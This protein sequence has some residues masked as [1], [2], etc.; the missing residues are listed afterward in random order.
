MFGDLEYIHQTHV[1]TALE[2]A[3]PVT[4]HAYW[5]MVPNRG[6]EWTFAPL[7]RWPNVGDAAA[8]AEEWL[9]ESFSVRLQST[10]QA[11][12]MGRIIHLF[13]I[14]PSE[15]VVGMT[16]YFPRVD[17][18]SSPAQYLR[19]DVELKRPQRCLHGFGAQFPRVG[20]IATDV[21]SVSALVRRVKR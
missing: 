5:L 1:I 9:V 21:L 2:A 12:Y 14:V 19:Q 17:W 15:P 4:E 16:Q 11:A 3:L 6:A 7:N 10:T 8:L 13:G 20:W 18:P